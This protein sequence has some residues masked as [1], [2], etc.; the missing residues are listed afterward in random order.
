MFYFHLKMYSK[1]YRYYS[2][3]SKKKKETH[4]ISKVHPGFRELK[5]N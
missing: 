3:E 1:A 4:L 2:M 5:R